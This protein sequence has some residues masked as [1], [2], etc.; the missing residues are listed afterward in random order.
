MYIHL[1]SP[2][3]LGKSDMIGFVHTRFTKDSQFSDISSIICMLLNSIFTMQEVVPR[4][5]EVAK[6]S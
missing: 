3:W 4:L 2:E 1:Y 5:C 6:M